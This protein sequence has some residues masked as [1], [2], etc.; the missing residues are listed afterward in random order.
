MKAVTIHQPWATLLITAEK[1]YETRSWQTAHRGPIALHAAR[2]FTD[3]MRTLIGMDPFHQ[4]LR[5]HGITK[6]EHLPKGAVIG[7]AELTDCVATETLDLEIAKSQEE[8]F[9]D[10]RPGRWAWKLANPIRF[11]TPIPFQGKLGLFDVPDD[12]LPEM[13]RKSA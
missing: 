5:K 11:Q 8:R 1:A 7:V 9:G 13:S 10:F 2:K 4:A 3:D 6:A 12:L